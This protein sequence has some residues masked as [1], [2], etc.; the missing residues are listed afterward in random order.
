METNPGLGLELNNLLIASTSHPSIAQTL[1]F[2]VLSAVFIDVGHTHPLSMLDISGVCRHWRQVA[3][4]T[5]NAWSTI[6]PQVAKSLPCQTLYLARSE[7]ALLHV[8]LDADI[9][10]A[11]RPSPIFQQTARIGCLT[12]GRHYLMLLYPFP[13]L[14]KLT[15]LPWIDNS[16]TGVWH[17]GSGHL[18]MSRFPR[19]KVLVADTSPAVIF[20]AL[21]MSSTLPPLRSLGV[22]FVYESSLWTTAFVCRQTLVSLCVN[23]FDTHFIQKEVL[24]LPRLRH[25]KIIDEHSKGITTLEVD[26]PHLVSVH[27]I[28]VEAWEGSTILTLRNSDTVTHLRTQYISDMI[29]YPTLQSLW[30]DANILPIQMIA[31]QVQASI[32][33][34]PHLETFRCIYTRTPNSE[35]E[36]RIRDILH[37]TGSTINVLSSKSTEV[38]LPGSVITTDTSCSC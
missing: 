10:Y 22:T 28:R 1:Y 24:E 29:T 8:T 16:V 34:C 14:E 38:D 15:L 20:D 11:T 3:L 33:L 25:L 19:L 31:F 9:D 23:I 2:D 32:N 5:P 27:R 6:S 36:T 7:P 12:M 13:N 37:A 21:P 30:L 35:L 18:E 26:A 17:V 4:A